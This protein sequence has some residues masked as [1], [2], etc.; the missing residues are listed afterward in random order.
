MEALRNSAIKYAVRGLYHLVSSIDPN[1]DLRVLNYGFY[2]GSDIPYDPE[3]IPNLLRLALY[4]H[5]ASAVDL[6]N[7]DVLEVGSGRGGGASYIARH[8]QPRSVHG[9]DLSG[10]AVRFCQDTYRVLGLSFS[11][12]DAE[13]LD[14]EDESFDVVINIESSHNYPNIRRFIA[15]VYRVLK[16]EGYF[17]FADMRSVRKIPE[18]RELLP[19]SGFR[20]ISEED[21]TQNVLSALD[22]DN[23]SKIAFITDNIPQLLRGPFSVFA[24]AKGTRF[25]NQLQTDQMKYVNFVLQK[26]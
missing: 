6:S 23:S 9:A 1:S 13:A 22:R 26:E 12:G 11:Q 16:P 21:I 8:L 18:L 5:V 10:K 24:G 3:D 17:L 25:Y 7:K 4:H 20:V 19:R 15:E 14:L 2:D